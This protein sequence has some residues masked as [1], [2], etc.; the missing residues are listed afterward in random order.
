MAA[1]LVEIHEVVA[2]AVNDFAIA[3]VDYAREGSLAV[4]G[5]KRGT[6]MLESYAVLLHAAERDSG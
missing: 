4:V 6:V 2:Q 3:A 1:G 5:R